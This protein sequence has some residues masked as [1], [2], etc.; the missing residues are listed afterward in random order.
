MPRNFIEILSGW[1]SNVITCVKWE[2]SYSKFVKLNCGVRQGG[3]LSPFLFALVVDDIIFDISRKKLGCHI[4]HICCGIFLYADDIILLSI[5]LSELQIMLDV[6]LSRLEIIDMKVNPNKS[7]C[8]RIGDRH[9]KPCALLVTPFG[10][11]P[12]GVELNFG[13]MLHVMQG[14]YLVWLLVAGQTPVTSPVLSRRMFVASSVRTSV[15]PVVVLRC[16]SCQS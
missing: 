13:F 12:W 4:S 10:P 3:V 5:S 8:I 6:C 16:D 11:I 9:D 14:T 2:S 15:V 7:L 1:Y